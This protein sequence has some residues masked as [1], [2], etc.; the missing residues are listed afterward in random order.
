MFDCKTFS[1][2]KETDALKKNEKMKSRA[3]I[4]YLIKYDF[5]NIFRIWNS[6]KNDVNDYRDVIFNETKFFDTYEAIDLF[7]KEERKLYVTYRA[8]SLQI[9]ENSDE[10][11]Y[12]RISIRKHVLINS[13]K[14]VVSKSMTKKEF[15]S[16]IE[17]QL[18]IFDD[19]SSFE[20]T[21]INIFVAVE[22]SKFLSRKETSNK[23]MINLSR[24]DHSLNKEN[25]IFFR[26]KSSFCSNSSKLSK[27]FFETENASLNVL[28][29]RNINSRINVANN[30]QEKRFRKSSKDFANTT[31]INEKMTRIFAF[32]TAMMIVF[33]TKALK[34]EIR[35]TLSFKFHISNLSKSSLHWRVMFRNSYAEN[36][37]KV[38]QIKYDVIETKRTWKIVEKR[39]D[40]KLISLKWIFI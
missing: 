35:T 8:I 37:L 10:K 16:S 31:W 38:A 9:F 27:E 28:T 13:R 18:F 14:N 24:K 26:K 7:K 1:F 34:L 29:S 17:S 25:N 5:I 22:I 40:Y 4:E 20:S 32:H 33:N 11:Q 39:D 2:L 36:V 12:D 19:T 6:K 15:S 23:E 3:F 30:V 21:S